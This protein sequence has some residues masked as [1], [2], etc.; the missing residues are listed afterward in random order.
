MGEE[1]QVVYLLAWDY[2]Y[3]GKD[4]LGAYTTR[5]RALNAAKKRGPDCQI[6][7]LPLNQSYAPDNLAGLTIE[8]V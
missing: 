4:F 6:V 5:R 1:L 3:E 7:E 8:E 2:G